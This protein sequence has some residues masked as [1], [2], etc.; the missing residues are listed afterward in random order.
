MLR[1]GAA[2]LCAAASSSQAALPAGCLHSLR[3]ASGW[4]KP[5]DD[6]LP[7]PGGEGLAQG[8]TVITCLPGDGIGPEVIKAAQAAVAATGAP[9]EWETFNVSGVVGGPGYAKTMPQEVM[10]SILKNK[11]CLK[12]GFFSTVGGGV[13]SL[14]LQLRK[15]RPRCRCAPRPSDSVQE[16][17]LYA[18]VCHAY[19]FPGVKARH[20]DVD[21]VIVR[22]NTE[23]EYSGLEHEVVP[24]VV[25]SIKVITEAKSRRIARYAFQYAQLNSR[26]KVTCVHKANIMK[27]TDG[28]F[29]SVCTEVA[30]DFPGVAFDQVI[31]DNACMQMASKPQQF[32]VLLTPNLY[33]NLIDNIGAGL[34]GG[35]GFLPGG[36]IGGAAAVFEQGASAGNVGI[37]Q[38]GKGIANPVAVMLSTAMMLKHLRLASFGAALEDAVYAVL[39]AGKVRTPDMGG[40]AT[41]AA[42][43]AAVC[44]YIE[45]LRATDVERL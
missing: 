9:V 26:A 28:L 18:H 17:D 4:A 10:D 2:A 20:R 35:A 7:I 43:T 15:A 31:V 40:E 11:A 34:V 13:S 3:C 1:R 19:N 6:A 44:D 45:R 42:F 30:K 21:V 16:L 32:D 22:E 29:L 12:G 36:S 39:G 8:A 23:G 41:S 37:H 38:A 27:L 5:S 25:E 24:G 14:T 33:G